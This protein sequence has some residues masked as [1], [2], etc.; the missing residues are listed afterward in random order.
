MMSHKLHRVVA[1]AILWVTGIFW[2][3]ASGA[4]AEDAARPRNIIIMIGDG[5]GYNHVAAS[6]FYT[7]GKRRAFAFQKFPVRLAVSTFPNEGGYDPSS[8]WKSFSAQMSGATDSAS[9]ATAISTG[10]KTVNGAIGVDP[11][12]ARLKHLF[13]Y[14]EERGK[15]TGVVTTM[16]WSHAT[17]AGFV[18]HN[19]NRNDY[20]AIAREMVDDSACEVIMGAGHPFFDDDGI[21]R[22]PP[23]SYQYVGG[24]STWE[25]LKEGVA[26]GDRDR[27][28]DA[29]H[30]VLIESRQEFRSMRAGAA[31]RRVLGTAQAHRTLQQER[32][33]GSG[34]EA[35]HTIARNAGVPTLREMTL[36]AINV[37]DSDPDGFC[38]MI[39]GGA[40]DRAAH[41]HQ[42]GRMIEEVLDFADAVDAVI[43]WIEKQGGWE[44]TLLIVTADHETGFLWGSGSNPAFNGIINR[45]AKTLPAFAWYSWSHSNAL[46]PLFACGAKA[47]LLL[48]E[49]TGSDP[50]RRKY[51]DNT[52]IGTVMI[53]LLN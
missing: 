11:A 37:L 43:H 4:L 32:T 51:L 14:A 28:G 17:P 8:A 18:A 26:G 41:A 42:G 9:A 49:L 23:I 24:E 31:P 39:E 2:F 30:W 27:D 38:L 35:P 36:A 48:K 6:G 7:A 44:R 29:D 21:Y 34:F 20:S 12:G 10:I 1:L 19:R 52:A 5:M 47:E 40:I 25:R 45:G 46:V 15:A 53:R 13:E 50:K 16:P 33:A 22:S 3:G